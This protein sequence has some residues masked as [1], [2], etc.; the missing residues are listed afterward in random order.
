MSDQLFLKPNVVIEPLID[1]WYAWAH[2]VSPAT[3][4]M[5]IQGRHL[6][7]IN[8]YLQ[9]PQIHAA[10]VKNPKMKG[11]P[12][13][14]LQG[15]KVEEVKN[16]RESTMESQKD[17]LELAKAIKE[18]D[19]MLKTHA[20]GYSLDPLY[21][22]VPEALQGYVE[23]TYDLNNV[24]SFRFFESLLYKSKYYKTSSQ[25]IALWVT[26]NDERP[27]CLSTPRVDDEDILNIQV[28]FK[29]E[30]ID[31]L[32]R[33]KRTAASY[34]H[35]RELLDIQPEDEPFFRSLFTDEAP[36]PYDSYKGDKIRMR[37]FG[38]ASILIETPETSILI[39]PI[40][41]YYGYQTEVSRYSDADLPDTIDYVLIT[42]NHQDHILL[43]TLLPLRHK[44]KNLVIPSSNASSLQDPSLK[45]MFKHL[46]F[47]NVIEIDEMEDLRFDD[48]VITG[49][50]FIGEHSDLN[51]QAKICYHIAIAGHTMLF[52]A[53]SCNIESKLYNHIREEIGEVDVFFL[54]MEC[55]GAPLT[56]LY[57]P[58]LTE[59]ISRDKDNSRRL[60]G[61]NF[62]RGKDLV[63]T[64]NPKE[65]Y[66]YAMGQEPWLEFISSIKYTPE[67]NTIVASNKLIEYCHS[68]EVTAER[69]FGEKELLYAKPLVEALEAN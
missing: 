12:F 20:Q 29:D 26:D 9:A 3:A 28:P 15:G 60:A 22:L 38:H 19:K 16:L 17:M 55:D 23:L 6:K 14:D 51:I 47:K 34:E 45:L 52:L 5:N 50:P 10:A 57:G 25:S 31:Y 69:L 65:V 40:I 39:D 43:E 18:L 24:P 1:R 32:S 59:D 67:S 21:E 2:L 42:H 61:S 13:M 62:Q 27:F 49:I 30:A 36:V 56:W 54:G 7:I 44:I 37:Y 8:S 41:S 33:M 66:V 48:C 64:F 11:G 4:A 58:L 35:I 63:D 53:D 68:K 46:G